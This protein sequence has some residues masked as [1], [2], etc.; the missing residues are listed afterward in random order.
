MANPAAKHF[1]GQPFARFHGVGLRAD[2]G[3]ILGKHMSL[4]W[5]RSKGG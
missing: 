3:F 4:A 1:P 5:L 2:L